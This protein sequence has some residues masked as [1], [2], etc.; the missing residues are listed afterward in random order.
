MLLMAPIPPLVTIAPVGDRQASA[1]AWVNAT[2]EHHGR[3]EALTNNAGVAYTHSIEELTDVELDDMWAV[4][5]N[6]FGR[7]DISEGVNSFLEKRPPEFPR[8]GSPE[9]HDWH[10]GTFS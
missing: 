9:A 8:L 3:L 7:V 10:R 2:V 5:E 4:L 1:E 6:Q